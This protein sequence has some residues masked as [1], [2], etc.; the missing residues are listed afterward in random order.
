MVMNKAIEDSEFDQ[1]SMICI[2]E[3]KLNTQEKVADAQAWAKHKGWKLFAPPAKTTDKRFPSA[4]VA[5]M[6]KPWL[7]VSN[8]GGLKSCDE[9]RWTSCQLEL[10]KTG[11]YYIWK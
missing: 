2:S 9:T 7:S 10:R 8:I 5:I 3:H 4:G 1:E 6:W 11:R